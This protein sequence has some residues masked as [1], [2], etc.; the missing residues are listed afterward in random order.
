MIFLLRGSSRASRC[1]MGWIAWSRVL[2]DPTSLGKN[3]MTPHFLYLII[4]RFLGIFRT[5]NWLHFA[6]FFMSCS[7]V[8]KRF[9]GGKMHPKSPNFGQ[10]IM[11]QN[12]A[13]SGPKTLQKSRYGHFYDF[14]FLPFGWP[15][16]HPKDPNL[17]KK[18]WWKIW[19]FQALKPSR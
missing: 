4:S 14:D 5:S 1:N 12:M 17:V 15:Q 7:M 16:W 8:G 10:K 18:S 11:I 13:F 9:F 19:H 3:G 6:P 2:T